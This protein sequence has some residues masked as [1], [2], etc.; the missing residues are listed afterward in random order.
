MPLVVTALLR[1]FLQGLSSPIP[2]AT[3]GVKVYK[4][5]DPIVIPL[6]PPPT[7]SIV[8]HAEAV[9]RP[10][11]LTMWKIASSAPLGLG[12]HF[13]RLKTT[14]KCS[15]NFFGMS[16]K[17]VKSKKPLKTWSNNIK[18]IILP[19]FN[20]GEE[21]D[22]TETPGYQCA[23]NSDIDLTTERLKA[24]AVEVFLTT[25]G[26]LMADELEWEQ[27]QVPG[28]WINGYDLMKID[29]SFGDTCDAAKT[30]Q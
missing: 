11:Q 17:T 30:L 26:K 22:L 24:K 25:N 2:P 15:T 8:S 20:L 5:S 29:F 28:Y 6:P 18:G 14:T 23:W 13:W 1:C 3:I 16:T 7:C 10:A 21:I 12:I 27:T 4:L 9:A 19:S